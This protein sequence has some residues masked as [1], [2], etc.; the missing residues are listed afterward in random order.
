MFSNLYNTS[1]KLVGGDL[2]S[3][4]L[5]RDELIANAI[6][7]LRNAKPEPR[8]GDKTLIGVVVKLFC[9]CGIKIDSKA[10]MYDLSR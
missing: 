10:T 1:K 5:N 6:I 4:H 3:N 7:N 8:Y 9:V 2:I